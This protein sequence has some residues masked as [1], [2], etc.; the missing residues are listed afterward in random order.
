MKV[1]DFIKNTTFMG[2]AFEAYEYR[3]DGCGERLRVIDVLDKQIK[4]FVIERE[5]VKILC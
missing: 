2:V 3:E 5:L 4:R 1:R